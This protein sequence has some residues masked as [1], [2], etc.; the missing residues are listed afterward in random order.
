MLAVA[1]EGLD[2][3]EG[4][5]LVVLAGDHLEQRTWIGDSLCQ[6]LDQRFRGGDQSGDTGRVVG[7]VGVFGEVLQAAAN[8]VV[9]LLPCGTD[10]WFVEQSEAQVAGDVADDGVAGLGGTDEPFEYLGH[11]RGGIGL[12]RAVA[13]PVAEQ[14]GDDRNLVLHALQGQEDAVDGFFEFGGAALVDG[15]V[16]VR[17]GAGEFAA[18][19]FREALHVCVEGLH[20]RVQ[21]LTRG[22]H[23]L[24]GALLVHRGT[25]AGELADIGEGAQQ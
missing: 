10:L 12:C 11:G 17:Q 16:V 5:N 24:V 20:E 18:E 25:V 19:R 8:A 7:C 23:A 22:V 14:G 21:M 6:K 3:L 1:V 15:G 2:V 4:A 9:D 13:E